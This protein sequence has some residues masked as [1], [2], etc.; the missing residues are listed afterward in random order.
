MIE[1]YEKS[2]PFLFFRFFTPSSIYK[3]IFLD[4][5]FSLFT[6]EILLRNWS[7]LHFAYAHSH[8]W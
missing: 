7:F 3:S 8:S 5:F 1:S 6:K 2:N 4:P